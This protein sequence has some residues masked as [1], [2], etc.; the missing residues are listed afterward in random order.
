MTDPTAC[1]CDIFVHP[2]AI[3]NPPGRDAISYCVGDYVAFREAL[4]R[5]APG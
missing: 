4:L 5:S 2:K 3:D 1:P